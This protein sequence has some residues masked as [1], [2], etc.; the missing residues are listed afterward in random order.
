MSCLKKCLVS[1]RTSLM[2]ALLIS[3]GFFIMSCFFIYQFKYDSTNTLEKLIHMDTNFDKIELMDVLYKKYY[4]ELMETRSQQHN[5]K[6]LNDFSIQDLNAYINAK[7]KILTKD[8]RE[9]INSLF[10]DKFR[11]VCDGKELID[12]GYSDPYIQDSC[13]YDS[14]YHFMSSKIRL[15]YK[16]ELLSNDHLISMVKNT[17]NRHKEFY[18]NIKCLDIKYNRWSKIINMAGWLGLF[19]KSEK[20]FWINKYAVLKLNKDQSELVQTWNRVWAFYGLE[21][22]NVDYLRLVEGIEY[23]EARKNICSYTPLISTL[24]EHDFAD[25]GMA[26]M[27]MKY[28]EIMNFCNKKV[29]IVN[30]EDYPYIRF[31]YCKKLIC[32]G[33]FYN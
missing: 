10:N 5:L 18:S 15:G 6:D 24:K 27:L 31:L 22:P 29:H 13:N 7:L 16:N 25:E 2:I 17:Y 20:K 14:V 19:D 3:F 8:D 28:I 9:N 32:Y 26:V 4:D 12:F 33:L 23:D 11:S 30:P 21:I 1:K